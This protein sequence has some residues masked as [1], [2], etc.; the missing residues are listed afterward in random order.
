MSLETEAREEAR[1]RTAETARYNLSPNRVQEDAEYQSGFVN[2][3]AW[4]VSRITPEQVE[5][6]L[7]A[8]AAQS[9]FT[10][11]EQHASAITA[12]YRGENGDDDA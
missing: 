8:T 12:L 10:S 1:Q 6:T 4:A 5:A 2:G 3:A 7:K 11:W 9:R